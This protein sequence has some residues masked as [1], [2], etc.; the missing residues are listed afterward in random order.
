[1]FFFLD[2]ATNFIYNKVHLFQYVFNF[3]WISFSP[4]LA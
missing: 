4:I 2:Y 3:L 1:M